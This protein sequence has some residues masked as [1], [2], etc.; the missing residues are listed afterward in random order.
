MPHTPVLLTQQ[1]NG[2]YIINKICISSQQIFMN[3]RPGNGPRQ[4]KQSTKTHSCISYI[5]CL[6][7]KTKIK[8]WRLG[9]LV[10]KINHFQSTQFS[11]SKNNLIIPIKIQ[12][13]AHIQW[14]HRFD[15]DP[16]GQCMGP[17]WSRSYLPSTKEI[18]SKCCIL[19]PCKAKGSSSYYCLYIF[20]W[21][22][23][24]YYSDFPRTLFIKL[25]KQK[26]LL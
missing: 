16:K 11:F 20:I 10:K 7:L 17:K 14:H 8:I 26:Y 22:M 13:L 4:G 5:K 6:R 21:L 23:N 25:L 24:N 1:V 9:G 15:Y 18:Y 12:R 3:V 2:R 19:C